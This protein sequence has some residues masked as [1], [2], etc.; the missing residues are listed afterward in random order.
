MTVNRFSLQRPPDTRARRA[1]S[2][3]HF[4]ISAIGGWAATR[5]EHQLA[6]ICPKAIALR[7]TSSDEIK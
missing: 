5:F 6:Q 3:F 7:C 1:S 2:I 4:S